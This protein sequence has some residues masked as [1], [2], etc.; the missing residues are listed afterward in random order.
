MRYPNPAGPSGQQS[1]QTREVGVGDIR[2]RTLQMLPDAAHTGQPDVGQ[3]VY[4]L[5]VA[6]QLGRTENGEPAFS[7]TLILRRQPT[8]EEETLDGLIQ[9][10][11]LTLGLT[12]DVPSEAV[13]A[14]GTSPDI[15]YRP[16]FARQVRFALA[17]DGQALEGGEAVAT[18]ANA[19]AGLSLD[20]D[21]ENTLAVLDALERVPSA[22]TVCAEVAYRT[23]MQAQKLHW[24]GNWA[25]IYDFLKPS[26]G[27]DN[28]I[29][30]PALQQQF[31]DLFQAD[32]LAAGY[33]SAS[34]QETPVAETER[35]GLFSAF[36][37]LA[38]RQILQANTRLLLDDPGQTYALLD[39]P[40]PYYALDVSQTSAG[41]AAGEQTLMLTA[42][43]EQLI[44]GLLD[45]RDANAYIHPVCPDPAGSGALVPVPPR[46][47]TP[48]SSRQSRDVS[49]APMCLAAT[50]GPVKSM[51]L[52]MRPDTSQPVP[53]KALAASDLARPILTDGGKHRWIYDDLILDRPDIPILLSLPVIN[54]AQ[55]SVVWRDRATPSKYWYA[56]AFEV[57]QPTP[58]QTADA[59]PF[60]FT[61]KSSGATA[62]GQPGLE[63]TIRFT[64]RPI[65]A[66]EVQAALQ[67]LGNPEAH[68]VPTNNLAVALSLPYLDQNHA[69]QT[70][71]L[72]ATVEPTGD[73]LLVT[74]SL[75]DATVRICYGALAYPNFQSIPAKLIVT[76]A[77]RAYVPIPDDD[78][79]QL[80]YGGKIAVTPVVRPEVM[81]KPIASR[82]YLDASEL[83]YKMPIGEMRFQREA[84][85]AASYAAV[86]RDYA[87]N[88]ALAPSPSA[89]MGRG[90]AVA[91]MERAAASAVALAPAPAATAT[92]VVTTRPAAAAIAPAAQAVAL[93][94][95][96]VV[97][98]DIEVAGILDK[99]RL[100]VHFAIQTQ[101]HQEEPV[102]LFPCATLGAFYLREADG[103]KAPIGCQDTFQLGQMVLKLYEEIPELK[104]ESFYRVFRSLQQP[105]RFLVLPNVYRI[106]RYAATEGSQAYH[107]VIVVHS[108][109]DATTA[110]NNRYFFEA[111]LEPDLPPYVRRE[112]QS[113]LKAYAASPV[114]EYP[115]E[116]ESDTAYAWVLGVTDTQHIELKAGNAF[117]VSFGTDAANALILESLLKNSGISGVATFTLPDGMALQSQLELNLSRI[118]GPWSSGPLAVQVQPGSATLTNRIETPVNVTQLRLYDA[119]GAMQAVPAERTLA[120]GES[121][122]VTLPGPAGE[123]QAVYQVPPGSPASIEEIATYL[124]DIRT[125]VIFVNLVN[126]ANHDLTQLAVQARIKDVDQ[127][128]NLAFSED[129]RISDV[130][131]QLPLTTYLDKHI[132]QFQ[133]TKTLSAGQSVATSWLEWDLAAQ[134]N[135]ISVTW[136]MIQ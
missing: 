6:P 37:R 61:Y 64:L 110:S 3:I 32:L 13:E 18:G 7:L 59:S 117:W 76:Y 108:A 126:Y 98:P 30:Y 68:P 87:P 118:V 69:T 49:A 43:L 26:F 54:D 71:R 67:A 114:V 12:L 86:V 17:K 113:R 74:V 14:L 94:P 92:A 121:Q 136:D 119:T 60:L 84:P 70:Q 16:L 99:L 31:L 29:P 125:N 122:Q 127:T 25:D 77:F 1:W 22:I 45:G 28:T 135:V 19:H 129:Q 79:L 106:T 42:P 90:G 55:P 8:P 132:L 2:P 48:S 131:I 40:S 5:P 128:Y 75:L 63:A 47:T 97:R 62:D 53:A 11:R 107:P 85:Q 96:V 72:A 93:K 46:V 130:A 23:V 95:G 10:G 15:A 44:G 41:L 123:V 134:G 91:L 58:N 66:Q 78:R 50:G 56:P 4:Y 115:T 65:M 82:A 109:H 89:S 102:A 101:F 104:N 81:E 100:Q 21:R 73:T 33:V 111:T 83:A 20:L 124:E 24:K 9:Q 36:L 80:V 35:A 34:G 103:E 51:A 27:A 120:P 105:G 112:L 116:I 38:N 88:A 39:R 133:V 52:A 57:V